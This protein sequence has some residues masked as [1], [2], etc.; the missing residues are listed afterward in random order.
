MTAPGLLTLVEVSL[1][2]HQTLS[3]ILTEIRTGRLRLRRIGREN[4]VLETDARAWAGTA[5]AREKCLKHQHDAERP[6]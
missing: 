5:K 4:F 1:R 3:E 2:Y 6:M